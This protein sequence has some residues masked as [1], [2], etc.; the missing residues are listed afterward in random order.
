MSGGQCEHTAEAASCP[1]AA[2]ACLTEFKIAADDENDDEEEDEEEDRDRSEGDRGVGSFASCL[3]AG[4]M[5]C[6][7]VSSSSTQDLT[8]LSGLVASHWF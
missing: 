6:C 1:N 8:F 2:S 3:F 7:R 4:S 5:N